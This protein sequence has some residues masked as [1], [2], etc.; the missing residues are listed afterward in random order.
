MR[1]STLFA[2]CILVAAVSF[3]FSGCYTVFT[4]PYVDK[5]ESLS[6]IGDSRYYTDQDCA[7][8]HM[9]HESSFLFWHGYYDSFNPS[10]YNSYYG[11][12]WWC[13]C[14]DDENSNGGESGSGSLPTIHTYGDRSIFDWD[15]MGKTHE[16]ITKDADL[17]T[18]DNKVN[19]IKI[20]KH[21]KEKKKNNDSGIEKD[22]NRS[23]KKIRRKSIKKTGDK[24]NK[25]SPAVKIPEKSDRSAD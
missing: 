19:Q 7:S 12:P 8:C 3:S 23:E 11:N 5:T 2:G 14:C 16:D 9:H 18:E 21:R 15:R 20:E 1:L 6:T 24:S 25:T 17:T 4:H 13:C 22:S 10:W